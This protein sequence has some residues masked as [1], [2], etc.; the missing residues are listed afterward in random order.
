MLSTKDKI[1]KIGLTILV[2]LMAGYL[3]S[4]LVLR[5]EGLAGYLVLFLS[6]SI[7]IV[8]GLYLLKRKDDYA[9]KSY[10]YT[11]IVIS[12]INITSKIL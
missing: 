8:Y 11:I 3:G 5:L 10:F 9:L 4:A 6:G 2:F 7:I 1:I 12:I